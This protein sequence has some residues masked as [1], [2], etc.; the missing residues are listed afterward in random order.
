MVFDGE[1]KRAY[2]DLREWRAAQR[3]T[4]NRVG[5]AEEILYLCSRIDALME[6]IRQKCRCEDPDMSTPTSWCD[7]DPGP[8]IPH[9]CDCLLYTIE[10][11]SEAS[12]PNARL[13]AQ[14]RRERLLVSISDRTETHHD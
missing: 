12:A 14:A 3:G 1:R 8:R 13:H 6:T 5:V 11:P 2:N 4:G 9:H 10:L 7:G